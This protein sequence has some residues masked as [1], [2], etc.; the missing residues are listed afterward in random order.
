MLLP[1]VPEETKLLDGPIDT[2]ANVDTDDRL[3]GPAQTER[4]YLP[5]WL[6]KDLHVP[7][8][9]Y[10]RHLLE[11]YGQ[12]MNH[13]SAGTS[14]D[15]ET[16]MRWQALRPIADVLEEL[17][18]LLQTDQEMDRLISDVLKSGGDAEEEEELVELIRVERD[19]RAAHRCALERKLYGLLI[20][21]DPEALSSGACMELVAGAG[22]REAGLFAR[23]LL[24]M[25]RS[26][27][28]ARG[29]QFTVVQETT[30]VGDEATGAG[31]SD[32]PLLKARVEIVGEGQE[33]SLDAEGEAEPD[34]RALGAFGQLRWESGVHRVQRIPVTSKQNKIHT[35][36]VAISVLPLTEEIHVELSENELKWDYFRASGAGGQHVNRTDSAV[37][38]THLPTGIVVACQQERSQHMNKRMAYEMLIEKLRDIQYQSQFNAVDTLRRSHFGHRDRSEKIRT[39]NFPQDRITDH[40]LSRTWNGVARFMR[41][42]VG[43]AEALQ[44][45]YAREKIARL[46]QLLVDQNNII[47]NNGNQ[48]H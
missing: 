8:E 38:L 31:S 24:D 9:N 43:L 18:V 16:A 13:I 34:C 32:S 33:E 19:Q 4:R 40:R 26:L 41:Q 23:D 29:W 36:T 30:M 7:F 11:E 6:P 10:K 2:S 15:K 5:V 39:Y 35:S 48:A 28:I 20:P 1:G 46:R 44:A 42:A 37:R 22:G 47:P 17:N 3:G 25:Y 45:L 14:K 12:L 21:P 27:A